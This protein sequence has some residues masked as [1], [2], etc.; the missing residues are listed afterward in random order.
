MG[1]LIV[2]GTIGTVAFYL[3]ELAERRKQRIKDEMIKSSDSPVETP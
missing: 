2:T 3:V 1:F